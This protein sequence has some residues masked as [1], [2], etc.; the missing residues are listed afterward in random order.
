MRDSS[1][2]LSTGFV[3]NGQ[4]GGPDHPVIPT[5]S[6]GQAAESATDRLIIRD[7]RAYQFVSLV[8]SCSPTHPDALYR[9]SSLTESIAHG[10]RVLRVV[11]TIAVVIPDS[12]LFFTL[13]LTV[14]G[15]DHSARI[16][17]SPLR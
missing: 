1:T 7:K 5:R 8:A 16:L 15:K 6:I 12:P 3:D 10:L 13:A 14:A 11:M 17:Q 2:R 4:L 9:D